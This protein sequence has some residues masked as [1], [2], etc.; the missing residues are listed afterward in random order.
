MADPAEWTRPD[1]ERTSRGRRTFVPALVGGAGGSGLVAIAGNQAWVEPTSDAETGAVAQVAS[2]AADASSPLATAVALVALACWGVVLVTRGRFRRLVAWFGVA[3]GLA[4]VVV[5]TAAFV[6]APE[7]LDEL[8]AVY[9]A[10]DTSVSRTAWSW[11]AVAGA[12]AALVAAVLGARDAG[13]W[14]QMG[15]R[16]DAPGADGRPQPAAP[17]EQSSI[18]LWKSLDEG[19]DPTR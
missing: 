18:D 1:A 16:Y 15:S 11:V 17:E 10:V 19:T 7:R 4:L 8:F 2:A 12:V 14:P 13:S 3:V 6:R 9:G 5:V